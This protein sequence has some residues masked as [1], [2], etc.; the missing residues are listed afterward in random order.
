[1]D[2]ATEVFWHHDY[3]AAV[4]LAKTERKFVLV[5]VFNPG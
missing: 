1:M 5:D 3:E 2:T 4:D